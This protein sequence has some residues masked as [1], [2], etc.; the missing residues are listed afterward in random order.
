MHISLVINLPCGI[1]DTD[2]QCSA[3][4]NH[5]RLY[6]FHT[7]IIIKFTLGSS[8]TKSAKCN[9]VTVLLEVSEKEIIKEWILLSATDEHTLWNTGA[10]SSWIATVATGPDIDPHEKMAT[11]CLMNFLLGGRMLWSILSRCHA[12]LGE[13]QWWGRSSYQISP[14]YIH[15]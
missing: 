9:L 14:L 4:R 10:C 6:P 2:F 12:E 7:I 5:K 15:K 3:E 8:F 13:S 1:L 11:M